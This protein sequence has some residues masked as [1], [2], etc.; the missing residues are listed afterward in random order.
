MCLYPKIIKNR[1]YQA[2]AKNNGIVPHM[3]DERVGYVPIACGRCMD[4]MR[5][6]SNEWRIRLM[7]DIRDHKNGKFITLTFSNESYTELN[8]QVKGHGYERDNNIAKLAVR[9][10]L[11]RWRKKNKKSVRHWLI[12][13]LG[14]G[15]TEHLHLHGIIYADDVNEIEKTW[16]YGFVWKGKMVRGA[17]VNYVGEKTINYIIKYV[18]KIDVKHKTYKPVILCSPGIG[19]NYVKRKDFQN[20]RYKPGETKETYTLRNGREMQLPIY[21]RNKAYTEEEREKL[22]IEKLDKNKLYIGGHEINAEDEKAYNTLIGY[23]R[24]KSA[25]LGYGIPADYLQA[26]WENQRRELI[27]LR[28]LKGGG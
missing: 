3:Q 11:E 26:E 19:G 21:L 9:R 12:T 17:L 27:R 18:T 13:E 28:R 16:R 24:M 5:K 8:K 4:C 7:E 23:Y 2:N 25:E 6:K 10:F 14:H 20:N 1:K 15:H 22:W